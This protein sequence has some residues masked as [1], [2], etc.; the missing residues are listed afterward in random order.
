MHCIVSLLWDERK[1]TYYEQTIQNDKLSYFWLHKSPCCHAITIAT[2]LY[3]PVSV[4]FTITG[5]LLKARLSIMRSVPQYWSI[6]TF[7]QKKACWQDLACCIGCT[8]RA[9]KICI[10]IGLRRGQQSPTVWHFSHC[11]VC[12]SD[13]LFWSGLRLHSDRIRRCGK[14]AGL[15][16]H[17]NQGSLFWLWQC[18]T[19]DILV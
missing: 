7:S 15:P 5:W 16:I 4:L 18:F 19:C 11:L 6:F 8:K 3:S 2:F 10:D 17:F 13:W 9:S 12:F 1:C 14:N